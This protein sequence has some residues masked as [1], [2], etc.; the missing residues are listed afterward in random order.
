MSRLERKKLD[1]F[2]WFN[3]W[4]QCKNNICW[5]INSWSVPVFNKTQINICEFT[6]ALNLQHQFFNLTA[7]IQQYCAFWDQSSSLTLKERK[8]LKFTTLVNFSLKKKPSVLITKFIH[9]F[10]PLFPFYCVKIF[11]R[12][13]AMLSNFALYKEKIETKI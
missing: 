13:G 2:S 8:M 5:Y 11:Y 9:Y 6:T 7:P 12:S 1:F 4:F 3:K 10:R